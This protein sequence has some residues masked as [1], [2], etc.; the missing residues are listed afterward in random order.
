MGRR[1]YDACIFKG[2]QSLKAEPPVSS[3]TSG[4]TR[5]TTQ[6]NVL[7]NLCLQQHRCRNLQD[8]MG[9]AVDRGQVAGFCE[10]ENAPSGYIQCWEF[11][12]SLSYC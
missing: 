1:G 8:Q 9:M 5:P 11:C 4:A 6:R 7:D 10:H 3:E 12:E 2:K